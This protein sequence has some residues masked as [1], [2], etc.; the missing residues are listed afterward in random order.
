M[1]RAQLAWRVIDCRPMSYAPRQDMA[2]RMAAQRWGRALLSLSAVAAI[3]GCGDDASGADASVRD[4]GTTDAGPSDAGPG[5][6]SWLPCGAYECT[7]V[8]VPADDV[9]PT[10]GTIEL[11]V[12]RAP[13]LQPSE[14]IGTLVFIVGGPGISG[15]DVGP[16]VLGDITSRMPDLRA[17]FD[18]VFYERRGAGGS[19]T[20]IDDAWVDDY[21]ATAPDP[22]SD[23]EWT[24]ID[25]LWQR[26]A[27]G[28]EASMQP[29][30]LA[31]LGS[32]T[33]ARD[34]DRI[35]A[36]LGDE[37]ISYF[38]VSGGTV[39][40]A[41]YASLFPE[42][43][44]AGLID[45][46]TAWIA[47]SYAGAFTHQAELLETAL[48]AFF[49]DCGSDAT[50]AFHGG[51]GA[52]AVAM[53]YDALLAEPLDVGGRP[54]G[55]FDLDYAV[56]A[57]LAST[58]GELA[59]IRGPLAE[60]LA[61]AEAGDGAAMLAASDPWWYRTATGYDVGLWSI[62]LGIFLADLPCPADLDLAAARAMWPATSATPPR[63]G[64]GMF[65]VSLSCL[66]WPTPRATAVALDA[67]ESPILVVAGEHDLNVGGVAAATVI[68]TALGSMA[69]LV[70]RD[71]YGHEQWLRSACVAATESSFLVDPS[72][73]AP[74]PGLVCPSGS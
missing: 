11:R 64:P 44:R 31:T 43:V 10:N 36:A 13:A 49:A 35:R 72:A 1:R 66:H 46:P 38:A 15:V 37:T 24:A 17:R 18:V 42:R 20:C 58:G 69:T 60:M 7:T 33:E 39:A 29:Y 61:D 19:L 47:P 6:L 54:A 50:C 8:E 51:A 45:S 12:L 14:R 28:C 34:I 53:A 2:L 3:S 21:R 40:G 74:P 71:G 73:W 57:T 56:Q 67:A 55:R 30:P 32:E 9:D 41:S 5:G 65:N 59:A 27:N 25:D 22:T 16:A 4:T 62:N 48:D 26:F 63:L 52:A 68:V 23:A 70:R